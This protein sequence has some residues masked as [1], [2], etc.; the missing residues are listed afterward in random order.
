M[1]RLRDRPFNWVHFLAV[2]K[3]LNSFLMEKMKKFIYNS[4]TPL[5][6]VWTEKKKLVYYVKSVLKSVVTHLKNAYFPFFQDYAFDT[7]KLL[8][9]KVEDV[10]IKIN[11]CIFVNLL[12]PFQFF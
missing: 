3:F 1:M 12:T 10:L 8:Q 11:H 7:K 9:N 5:Y 6:A 4:K 2:D